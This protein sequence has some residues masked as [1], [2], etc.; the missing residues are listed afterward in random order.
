MKTL[1]A[2]I[3]ASSYATSVTSHVAWAARRLGASVELLHV[4][5][6]ADAVAARHDLS[7]AMGVGARDQLLEELV[8]IDEA[9]GKL[10]RQR[11]RLLLDAAAERLRESGVDE[12][13]TT[14]RHG[15]VV[16]TTIE[17]EE[18]ADVLVIGK[19]GA[20]HE[21]APDHIGSTVE[22]II[23]ESIRPVL[24]ASREY[25]E[26]TRVLFAHDGGPSATKAVQFAA[27]SPL[28]DG[29]ELHVAHAAK[30]ASDSEA[31]LAESQS[32]LP[33]ARAVHLELP[34]H[35]SIPRY[36]EEHDIGMIVM[37]AYGHSPLR[38]YIVGSTTTSM[39]LS[40]HVP[41]LLFR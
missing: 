4:I 31:P 14:H 39:M 25:R 10:A 28:F 36:V 24:V 17:R 12:V 3:D 22:R 34:P 13:V 15:G 19:R 18:N 8:S 2:C 1:L 38:R 29:L 30:R 37:G 40:S 20:S 33:D 21:F 26:P 7:G 6:R 5:Q 16:E 35:E 41:L 11:G 23:R 32:K 9:E 27:A